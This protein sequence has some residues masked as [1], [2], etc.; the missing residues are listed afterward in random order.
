MKKLHTL[1]IVGLI[2]LMGCATYNSNYGENAQNLKTQKQTYNANYDEVYRAVIRTCAGQEWTIE[3]SEKPAGLVQVTA[4]GNMARWEDQISIT[5]T[6][7][8]SGV[9]VKARSKLGNAPNRREVS[10]FF[11]R[12][13]EKLGIKK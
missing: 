12:L 1:T 13:D 4:P 11:E 10:D 2:L 5:V 9:L 6:K 7:V 3:H 8:E